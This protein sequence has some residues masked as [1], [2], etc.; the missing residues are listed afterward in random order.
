MAKVSAAA[1][2]ALSIVAHASMARQ[3][4]KEVFAKSGA[5]GFFEY[6][7]KQL[8]AADRAIL[9]EFGRLQRQAYADMAKILEK[10]A[11]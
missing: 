6:W 5:A 11:P 3:L 1:Q 9:D 8:T 4:D 7:K 2:R 10:D